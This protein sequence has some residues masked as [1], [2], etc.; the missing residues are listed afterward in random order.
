MGTYFDNEERIVWLK[1]QEALSRMGYV[2]ERFLLAGI[3]TG[4]VKPPEGEVLI[5]YAVLKRSAAGKFTLGFKR[6]IFTL[7]PG[8]RY[9]DPEG[10]F[11]N[12]VPPEAV[13]PCSVRVGKSGVRLAGSK[14]ESETSPGDV[15]L[16]RD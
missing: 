7:Q 12:F 10:A 15:K 13:D 6:R 9:F 4:P 14:E 3:R 11:Q 8:D 16:N 5:G 1:D 2:R